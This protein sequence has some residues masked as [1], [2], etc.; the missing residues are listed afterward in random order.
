MRSELSLKYAWELPEG[1][2]QISSILGRIILV[3]SKTTGEESKE[4]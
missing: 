1:T 3:V 2:K 4:E